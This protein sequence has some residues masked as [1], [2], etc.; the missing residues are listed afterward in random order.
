V[1]RKDV[2]PGDLGMNVT[3]QRNIADW[4]LKQRSETDSAKAAKLAK[5]ND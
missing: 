2:E 1:V 4:V 5:D 3:P